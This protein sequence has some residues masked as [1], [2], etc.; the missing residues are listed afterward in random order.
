MKIHPR[1]MIVRAGI[2]PTGIHKCHLISI[3][4]PQV[5]VANAAPSAL[6]AATSF[7]P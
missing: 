5:Q 1:V 6:I 3:D 4:H 2:L 7:K